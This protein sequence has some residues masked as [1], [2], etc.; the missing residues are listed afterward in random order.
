M[1]FLYVYIRT[2]F[3]A[4][5]RDPEKGQTVNMFMTNAVNDIF[6]ATISRILVMF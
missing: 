3:S 4:Y 5:E 6:E 1:T 2:T